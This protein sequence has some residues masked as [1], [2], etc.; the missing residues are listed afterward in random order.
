MANRVARIYGG[1]PYV[2]E[3]ELD[4]K[5]YNSNSLNVKRF[6]STTGE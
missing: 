5:I 6:E 3:F 2:N 4:E 1:S